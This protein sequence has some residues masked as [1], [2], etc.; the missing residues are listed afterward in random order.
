[1]TDIDTKERIKMV[2]HDLLMQYGIRS[3]SMDDIAFKLGMS[4]KTIYLYYKDKD[5]LVAAVVDAKISR[6]TQTCSTNRQQ[7]ENAIHEI[8][9]AMDMMVEMFGTMN[10][11]VLFDMQKYHPAAF[12]IFLAHKNDFLYNMMRQN[13]ER[14]IAEELYRPEINVVIMA[15]F[16]IESM[17]IPFNPEFI[18]N[19]KSSLPETGQQTLMHFLY[20]LVSQ[21]GYKVVL[22]YLEQREN[23]NNRNKNL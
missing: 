5:E 18:H 22:K 13:I 6:N 8:F 7:A 4:K 1:M 16:R 21:K 15:R 11:S 3:I 9:L 10:P 23:K 12:S 20:G 19:T 17:F 2:S 14:G